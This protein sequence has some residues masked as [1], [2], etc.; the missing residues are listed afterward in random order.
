M[1]SYCLKERRQTECLD[2]FDFKQTNDGR[3]MFFSKCEECGFRK[4]RFVNE[5]FVNTI[6]KLRD[7]MAK[8]REDIAAGND[9]EVTIAKMREY[10]FAE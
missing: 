1:K 9:S 8:A 6:K 5:K 4:M 7:F 2:P 10:V 3:W